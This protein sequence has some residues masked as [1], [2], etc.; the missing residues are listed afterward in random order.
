MA[1]GVPAPT[2]RPRRWREWFISPLGQPV[3][4]ALFLAG[5]ALLSRLEPLWRLGAHEG[6][7]DSALFVLGVWQWA[8]HGPLAPRIYDRAFSAGYYAVMSAAAKGWAP[9]PLLEPRAITALM[10]A[11]SV[12]AAVATALLAYTLAR[13]WLAPVPAFAS[14]L[15]FILAPGVWQLG[16]EPHPEGVGIALDLAALWL[17]LRAATGTGGGARG[18]GR[19]SLFALALLSAL[20]TR[21]DVV[22]FFAAFPAALALERRRVG[23]RRGGETTQR[24]SP[25]WPP[26]MA[27]CLA[28]EAAALLVYFPARS[29]ILGRGALATERQSWREIAGYVGHLSLFKQALPFFTGPGPAVM[30]WAL[31]GLALFLFRGGR[32]R[33]RWLLFALAWS[34]PGGI[35]WLLVRGNNV[36]HVALYCLPWLWI[37]AVGWMRL[38]RPTQWLG[39]PALPFGHRVRPRAG[40]RARASWILALTA[41]A[42]LGLDALIPP[43]SNITLY[44]SG[45]VPASWALLVKRQGRMR[46]TALR[47]A[48]L[49]ADPAPADGAAPPCYLGATTSPYVLLYLLESGEAPP[50][51]WRLAQSGVVTTVSAR[52]ALGGGALAEGAVGGRIIFHDV[53]S[54]S[55]YLAAARSCHPALSWE[56]NARGQHLWFFGQEWRWLPLHRRWY[57]AVATS[58]G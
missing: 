49:A 8:R 54:G 15:L 13:R 4:A 24:I 31:A 5:V 2:L 48:R 17:C 28:A 44:P 53:Y 38:G 23:P 34:A 41:V 20:L 55:E 16:L 45:N 57:A 42:T 19:W 25:R 40:Q 3:F 12:A 35:F 21:S 52:G 22:F 56:Y 14:T 9:H 11:V 39:R 10:D 32:A 7:P 43:S 51:G 47:L 58:P 27:R 18:L 29:A 46:A 33:A 26:R 1:A 50:G 37:A 36:R 30:L 6:E